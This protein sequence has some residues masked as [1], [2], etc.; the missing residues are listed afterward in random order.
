MKKKSMM[1]SFYEVKYGRLKEG[2]GVEANPS[3]SV[4]LGHTPDHEV[5]RICPWWL[6]VPWDDWF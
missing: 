1:G 2:P 4:L 6:V 3:L 5:I